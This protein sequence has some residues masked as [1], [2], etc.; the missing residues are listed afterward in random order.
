MD[1]DHSKIEHLDATP[2]QIAAAFLRDAFRESCDSCKKKTDVLISYRWMAGKD[3][4]RVSKTH[5]ANIT[6]MK[7]TLFELNYGSV[8]PIET[9]LCQECYKQRLNRKKIVPYTLISLMVV[10]LI[11]AGLILYITQDGAALG[12]AIL[13]MIPTLLFSI[14]KLFALKKD[15][16]KFHPDFFKQYAE[17][18]MLNLGLDTLWNHEEYE[19]II[20]IQSS[21]IN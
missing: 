19:K 18:K 9:G 20:S 1:E 6:P 14:N 7:G 4:R 8:T 15:D 5:F 12:V 13:I 21:R 11:S 10:M 17:S 16:A 3:N 2:R